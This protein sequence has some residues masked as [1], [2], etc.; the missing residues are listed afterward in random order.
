[1]RNVLIIFVLFFSLFGTSQTS[2]TL[3]FDGVNDY[4][5]IGQSADNIRTIE[6]W[7]KL[8][9][10]I[11]ADLS[12]TQSMIVRN[13]PSEYEEIFLAFYQDGFM[14]DLTGRLVFGYNLQ[15]SFDYEVASNS[16]SWDADRWY[17]VAGVIHPIDGMAIFIDGIKQDDTDEI[18]NPTEISSYP[19]SVGRWGDFDIR[20]FDGEI[21][22]LRFS[23]Y[24]RYTVNF[25]P[26]CPPLITDEE[27]QLLF[28][29]EEGTGAVA[30]DSSAIDNDGDIN[31]ASWSSG[32]ICRIDDT[33]E[34]EETD[35]MED[36]TIYPNPASDD[37]NLDFSKLKN[38]ASSIQISSIDGQL[39][40]TYNVLGLENLRLNVAEL[41]GFYLL[42]IK[43]ENGAWLDYKFVVK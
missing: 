2:G 1:M 24:A 13:T 31:G 22:D 19:T 33:N 20:Y 16:S 8:N 4:V 18:T 10:S 25:D 17:H 6:L 14:P 42:R 9:N 29:F 3:A 5:D 21:E 37:L 38:K 36:A 26:P 41:N 27:T 43:L 40:N 28:N 15:S 34:I 39:I 30:V 12:V 35:L 7:F 23:T 11:D 32:F